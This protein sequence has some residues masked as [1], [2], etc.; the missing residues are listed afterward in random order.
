VPRAT[1]ILLAA[2][3]LAACGG[4]P[5]PYPPPRE[6]AQAPRERQEFVEAFLQG[7]WCEAEMLFARSLDGFLRADDV[8]AAAYTHFLAYR[9]K[10]FAGEN[11]Q[12]AL[13]AARRYQAMGLGCPELPGIPGLSTAPDAGLPPKD[14][15]YLELIE[16]GDYARLGRELGTEPDALYASV[17]GR[18]AARAALAAGLSADAAMLIGL[19]RDIDARQGW[20]VFLVNDWTFRRELSTD[21]VE[22]E[23]MAARITELQKRIIPCGQ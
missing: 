3:F 6:L 10:G 9:L 11:D 7:R 15:R 16:A 18:K 12:A 5:S 22:R 2:V 23:A 21:P 14:R 17:Y 1:L 8:C 13:A 20:V 19:A 4:T